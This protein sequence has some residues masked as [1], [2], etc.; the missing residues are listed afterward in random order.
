LQLIVKFEHITHFN[1]WFIKIH[2]TRINHN[3]Q[4]LLKF[5]SKVPINTHNGLTNTSNISLRDQL[6]QPLRKHLRKHLSVR[7][8][9]LYKP[10][11]KKE[12]TDKENETKRMEMLMFEECGKYE[13]RPIRQKLLF[14]EYMNGV[15]FFNGMI[16]TKGLARKFSLG[17]ESVLSSLYSMGLSLNGY[18]P[19]NIF[20]LPP[21]KTVGE[22][23]HDHN[24]ERNKNRTIYDTTDDLYE[25]YRESIKKS[26]DG[27]SRT[28]SKK[29][30]YTVVKK[31]NDYD[32]IKLDIDVDS[33]GD[34]ENPVTNV[35]LVEKKDP[36]RHIA[37]CGMTDIISMSS[38]SGHYVNKIGDVNIRNKF[39]GSHDYNMNA[40][41]H[42][43]ERPNAFNAAL[44]WTLGFSLDS[45]LNSTGDLS[46]RHQRTVDLLRNTAKSI[47]KNDDKL[48]E[49]L[50]NDFVEN[51][52][53]SSSD[54]IIEVGKLMDLYKIESHEL[55][56]VMYQN[57]LPFGMG[58]KNFIENYNRATNF[59]LNDAK[60]VLEK[61]YFYVDYLHGKPIKNSF[62]K[63]FGE[64]QTIYRKKY[65]DRTCEGHFYKCFMWLM[66][67]K[68]KF[69]E[70]Y[71]TI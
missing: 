7:T 43:Y 52:T 63:T 44:L 19:S 30:S 45:K 41:N 71:I 49:K 48:E 24:A 42:C 21:E 37:S 28:F 67:S 18:Q 55:L 17:P 57:N 1:L 31:D 64:K 36:E 10:I 33:V 25:K 59:T 47:S 16:S 4:Q 15:E 2:Q 6:V 13:A 70:S 61:Q 23:F 27:L 53:H 22:I 68:C 39:D 8:W 54:T 5:S 38:N 65:D 34:K 14:S 3:M 29:F 46:I 11:N 20:E 35:K 66:A 40:F 51:S 69:S 26:D 58:I 62:R 50:F 56:F 60:S 9:G 32:V 12:L